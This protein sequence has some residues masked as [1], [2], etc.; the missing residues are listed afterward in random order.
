MSEERTQQ[1]RQQQQDSPLQTERGATRIEDGVVSKIAGIAAQEVDG[2]R[3]GGGTS[4]AIGGLLSSVTGGSTGGGGQSRGVSVEVGEV[5]AAI[6]ATL[7][8]AYGRSIPQVAEAVRRNIINRVENLVGL[9][10]TEVNIAV[11]DVF[12]PEQ[13]RQQEQEQQQRQLEQQQSGQEQRVR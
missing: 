9:N 12:F 3:M 7:T 5:E 2:V 8:V 11:N 4:Q 6:D 13:E 1:Q 10:V